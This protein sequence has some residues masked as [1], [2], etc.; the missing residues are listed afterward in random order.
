MD[1]FK[2]FAKEVGIIGA[3]TIGAGMFA[4]PYIFAE[5][6]WRIGILYLVIL[7]G[8]IIVAHAVY[9]KVLE[10]GNTTELLGIVK[11]YT[12]H[13]GYF[14]GAFA[15]IGGLTLTLT[16]FLM[17]GGEFLKQFTPL[18]VVGR[19]LIF[20]LIAVLPLLFKERRIS[21]FELAGFSA[22]AA[23]IV[24]VFFSSGSIL[25]GARA[26]N[27]KNIFLP[28]GAVLFALTG[29]P[30]IDEIFLLRNNK[31]ARKSR[32]FAAIAAGTFVAAILYVLFIVGV[33]GSANKVTPDTISG[34][35]S[36]QFKL[37][38]LSVLGIINVWTSYLPIGLEIK[39]SLIHELGMRSRLA[40]A[41]VVLTPLVIA[42]S[43]NN[44]LLKIVGLTGG[45]FLSMQYFLIVIAGDRA[46]G[47]SGIRKFFLNIVALI[48]IL[49][50]VYEIYFF[51]VG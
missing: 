12:G 13:S 40:L 26:F 48:F 29:W 22:A 6:G 3:T 1:R 49:A 15:I 47:L 36:Q 31:E 14:V 17:L 28:F 8:V 42:V 34:F 18:G 2:L 33:F 44:N 5:V 51:M 23:I 43:L 19:I 45:T 21:G 38:M 20:W 50:A 10:S 9:Y 37:A 7:S 30:A 46:L 16:I 4:L 11:K 25:V 39:R 35:S 24:F 41:A 27:M 32:P